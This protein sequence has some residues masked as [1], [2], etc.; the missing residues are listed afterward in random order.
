MNRRILSAIIAV[1]GLIAIAL[2]VCSATIW[3]PGTTAEATL[4]SAPTQ[5]YVVTQPGVLNRVDSE[6][7]ITA[8]AASEDEQVFIA[9]GHS[10]DVNAWLANDPYVSVTGLDSWTS[11]SATEVTTRCGDDAVPASSAP[12]ASGGASPTSAPSTDENGCTV[13]EASNADPSTSDLWVV[14]AAGKG[15][16][17]LNLDVN[18][19]DLVML[20]ATDGSSPAPNIS[21]SWPRK[22]STPWLIP[23]LILGGLLLLVGVFLFLIDIQ[24][25]HA[26]QQRRARSAERAARLAQA[27]GVATAGIPRIGDPNRPLSRREMRE[28]E[29]AASE[30][31]EWIDPRTGRVYL[32]GV[33][34]PDVPQASEQETTSYGGAADYQAGSAA[35]GA[36]S[37]GSGTAPGTEA[38]A[39]FEAAGQSEGQQDFSSP[40]FPD[41]GSQPE[42]QQGFAGSGFPDYGSQPEGQQGF[43]GSGFPDYGSQPEGQQGFAGPGFPDYGSQPEGQQDFAGSGFPDYGSQPEGQ[44][45][46]AGP[47]FPDYGSQPEGQQSFAGPGFPDTTGQPEGQQGFA[48]SGFPD[49]GSQP[50]GQQGFAGSGF[51]DYGSQPEGQQGF[52]GPGFPDYGSQ[53]ETQQ[54]FSGPGFP[55]TAGQPETQQGFA[56]PGFPDTTGQPE[57]QQSFS[58]PGFP[59]T[60][61]QPETQQDFSFAPTQGWPAEHRRPHDAAPETPAGPEDEEKA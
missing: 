5:N 56:G 48:G 52:S 4:A 17:T 57:G 13:L 43:A 45:D 1:L 44:Q 21:L 46:F 10:A 35:E 11:L 30:G 12:S 49:Y 2:A 40:G 25:R 50:E 55:D 20:S 6:A 60:T 9:V 38:G 32:G 31:E 42:G 29:R 27:D 53:P 54:D 39:T 33:E 23:G 19:T 14:T 15:T 58:G 7:T 18:D 16:A 22:V 37:Y 34:A 59:D 61:G 26:D 24:M 28:K 47:G 41:Y 8:T 3:R 36:F 51:P